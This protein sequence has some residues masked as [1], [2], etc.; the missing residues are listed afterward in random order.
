MSI[1]QNHWHELKN[2]IRQ[3]GLWRLVTP[4]GYKAAHASAQE[5]EEKL[6]QSPFD[7]LMAASLMIHEQARL[8]FG[9]PPATSSDCPLCVVD[10]NLGTEV[11]IEWVE[12]EADLILQLCREQH[13]VAIEEF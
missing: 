5:L 2:A 6:R 1:C 13:L 12:T 10:R 4:H 9:C 11:S 3:R 8:A 7:P